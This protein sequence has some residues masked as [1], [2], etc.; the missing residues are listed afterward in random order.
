MQTDQSIEMFD[1]LEDELPV[2]QEVNGYSI[3]RSPTDP[4][5]FNV[6]AVNFMN[7]PLAILAVDLTFE[8]AECMLD[9]LVSDKDFH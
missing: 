6:C 9:S 1:N 2:L 8:Q 5:L 4:K 7:K 3:Y